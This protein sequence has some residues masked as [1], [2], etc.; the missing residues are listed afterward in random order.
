MKPAF[1]FVAILLS[2]IG[3]RGFAQKSDSTKLIIRR[4]DDFQ[5]N[6]IGD[7]ANWA[8]TD[9][10]RITPQ[11]AAGKPYTTKVKLL[12]STTGVYFLFQNEDEKLTSTIQEDYGSLFKEDVIEVFLWPDQ[13]VPI[14]FE[15][16]LSPL[17]YELAILVPN[18]NGD[19]H[20][21][22][23][24]RYEGNLKVQ[25]A[26]STQGGPRVSKG[27]VTGWT[28]EFF[29][30]YRLLRPIVQTTPAPGT[31][32]RGN[33]YRIDY[34][35]SYATWSWQKTSGSFHEFKKYGTFIFE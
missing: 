5:V 16:E 19:F 22:K 21:W 32:W 18:I 8:K 7:H 25:H 1:F 6:G 30:P 15:Y 26:T 13:S 11:E 14:Y 2:L 34:D 31:Q 33:L 23:P 28:G 9:W 3:T 29:I 17:N 12:Y 10:V 35:H 20:G 27:N 4:T 24:W